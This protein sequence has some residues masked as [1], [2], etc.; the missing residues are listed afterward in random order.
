M[1]KLIT[2]IAFLI[3]PAVEVLSQVQIGILAGGNISRQNLSN[4]ESGSIR[5]YDSR[6]NGAKSQFL[7]GFHAG[8][9]LSV[10]LKSSIKFRPS[11]AYITKG[12][13]E[14][15]DL[16]S[17]GGFKYRD[18]INYLEM[19]MVFSFYL[20]KQRNWQKKSV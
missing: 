8:A 17:S 10:D 15:I 16:Q 14:E 1:K 5:V 18:R 2:A 19:P 11:I 20:G 7:E 6:S 3:F 4:A 13:V 12:Q 9:M